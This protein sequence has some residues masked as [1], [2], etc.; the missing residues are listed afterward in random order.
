MLTL[1]P[2]CARVA[3][4]SIYLLIRQ[5]NN[6]HKTLHIM[7]KLLLSMV[8]ALISFTTTLAVDLNPF[9]YGLKSQYDPS[10]MILSVDFSLNAPASYMRL[11]IYD[12]ET[13][14]WYK[15]Y[16]G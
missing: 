8:F 6:K 1:Q 10:S 4:V 3:R 15:E 5:L 16:F 13:E 2:L 14:V 11:S 9:A 12:G 7:K